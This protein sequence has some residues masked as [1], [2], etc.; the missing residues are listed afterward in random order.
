[1]SSRTLSWRG[2]PVNDNGHTFDEINT[3]IAPY[4]GLPESLEYMASNSCAEKGSGR[5]VK[6]K[7][8]NGGERI[9]PDG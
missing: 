1:V 5:Q 8:G 2:I 4:Q 7:K 9:S 6:V 3:L